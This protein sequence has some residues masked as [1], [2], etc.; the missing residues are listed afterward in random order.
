MLINFDYQYRRHHLDEDELAIAEERGL[1]SPSA[2]AQIEAQAGE[3]VR[4][5]SRDRFG[6]CLAETCA[7]RFDLG[8]LNGA[9]G[10]AHRSIAPGEADGWLE[11]SG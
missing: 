9:R 11:G 4:L 1:L 5:L 3:L 2:R 6:S 7:A 8:A 10:W